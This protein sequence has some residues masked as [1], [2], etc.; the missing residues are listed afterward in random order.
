MA[1]KIPITVALHGFAEEREIIMQSAFAEADKWPTPWQITKQLEQ[2]RV[3]IVYLPSEEAYG[4][5]DKLGRD[6]PNAEV[7]ALSAKIPP[8][9]K[10]HL[11]RQVTGKVSIVKFS[12]LVLKIARS[13]KQTVNEDAE[14]K[15]GLLEP[16]INDPIPAADLIS[17]ADDDFEQ[18]FNDFQPFF[19]T[20]DT[21]LE[22]KPHEKRKRFN[23]S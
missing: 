22:S 15:S 11:E 18:E 9:A 6:L 10:W 1:D 19:T 7:V 3:V 5:L 16:V 21:L 23:E 4:E 14:A 17:V 13:L 12:Q 8:Q 20:L 2:A